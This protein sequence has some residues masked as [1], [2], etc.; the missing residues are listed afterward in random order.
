MNKYLDIIQSEKIIPV[1]KIT[2]IKDTLPVLDA[3]SKE[4]INIAEI[5]FR[6]PCASEAIRLAVSKR[7]NM[8]I[9]AGTVINKEQAKLALECGAEFIVSPG[10]SAEVAKVC[11]KTNT[12]YIPGCVSPT[13][14]MAA[15][16]YGIHIVKFFPAEN[17]GGVGTL[18]ALAA[19]FPA[20]RFVPTGGITESNVGEYLAF[21]R[22]IACGASFMVK[23]E[24]ITKGNFD[25]ISE[26]SK[27]LK[28]KL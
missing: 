7:K 15:L 9:G 21:D 28:E 8:T 10:F 23:D 13:D 4:G 14:I 5:T 18:R 1:V 17:Y 19:A 6:T 16:S 24:Y 25:T 11:N 20:V 3:L 12:L 26:L 22:V 27:A 2:D